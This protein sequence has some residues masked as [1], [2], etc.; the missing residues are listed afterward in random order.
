MQPYQQQ[1]VW[2]KQNIGMIFC[3]ISC[4]QMRKK[5]SKTPDNLAANNDYGTKN[6]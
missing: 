2:I 6:K 4:H 1:L 5:N 3:S